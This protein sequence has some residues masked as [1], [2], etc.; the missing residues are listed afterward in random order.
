MQAYVAGWVARKL[1]LDGDLG[2]WD[3]RGDIVDQ[4]RGPLLCSPARSTFIQHKRFTDTANL[5]I[6][7]SDVLLGT[8][9]KQKIQSHTFGREKHKIIKSTLTKSQRHIHCT[10]HRPAKACHPAFR[11]VV[12]HVSNQCRA[13]QTAQN[14]S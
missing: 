6:R 2:N 10:T 7:P 4:R 14:N 11:A 12:R 9:E 3:R 13:A 5:K 8:R 1:S